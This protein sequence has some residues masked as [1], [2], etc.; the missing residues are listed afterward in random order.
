MFRGGGILFISPIC[1]IFREMRHIYSHTP[2]NHLESNKISRKSSA[3]ISVIHVASNKDTSGSGG[4]QVYRNE[5]ADDRC[6]DL[7]VKIRVN[8]VK[9]IYLFYV[10]M[11]YGYS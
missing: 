7:G 4:I 5:V 9:L 1:D 2:S 8:N 11:T 6:L 10:P 3:E